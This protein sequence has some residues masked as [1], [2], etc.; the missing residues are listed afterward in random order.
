MTTCS[1]STASPL[2]WALEVFEDD[3]S[4]PVVSLLPRFT[5]MWE[6][7]GHRYQPMGSYCVA[8][9]RPVWDAAGVRFRP[10]EEPNPCPNESN[11]GWFDTADKANWELLPRTR[12]AS[13]SPTTASARAWWP[14]RA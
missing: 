2:R 8:V 3:P 14:G 10:L 1:S 5:W 9:Q 6:L 4:V 11:Q 7:D 12:R 13:S